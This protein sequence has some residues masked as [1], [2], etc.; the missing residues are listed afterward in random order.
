MFCPTAV[1]TRDKGGILFPKRIPPLEPPEKGEG[2]TPR[3]PTLP[4]WSSKSCTRCAL[5]SRWQ[6]CCLTDVAYPLRVIGCGVHGFAMNPCNSR[7]LSTAPYYREA[8]VTVVGR[9]TACRMRHCCAR[10]IVECSGKRI[11]VSTPTRSA[12]R[13]RMIEAEASRIAMLNAALPRAGIP[14][15]EAKGLFKPETANLNAFLLDGH[16][17]RFLSRGKK[18]GGVVL[19]PAGGIALRTCAESHRSSSS[20][21]IIASSC[22]R[23]CA[24]IGPSS[25]WS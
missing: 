11:L 4:D 12:E 25:R 1:G 21:F 10:R 3:P 5:H 14:I 19:P 16:T 13:Q 9:Q 24:F 22:S 20:N 17:A 15:P 7:P 18:M 6:L 2:R 8:R 23:I